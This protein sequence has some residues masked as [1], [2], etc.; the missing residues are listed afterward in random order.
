M[1]VLLALVAGLAGGT[2]ISA[3]GTSSLEAVVA[4]AETVGALWVAALRM[5]VVPLVV[6]LLVAS[7]ASAADVGAL[8]RAGGRAM[9]VF[10]ALLAVSATV[11]ALVAPALLGFA[12]VAA[13]ATQSPGQADLAALELAR[14]GASQL[15]DLGD[16]LVSLVPANPV[17]AAADGALLPLVVFSVLFAAAVTRLRPEQ[18]DRVVGPVEAIRDAMLVLV[19]W[20]IALAPIGVFALMLALGA[21]MGTSGA[22]ALGYYVILVSVLLA[23]QALLL[24]PLARL[25]GGVSVTRFARA[26]L[27]AQAVA[28]STRSSLAALPALVDGA[29]QV[30]RLP[31]AVAGFVL[32]LAVSVFK[33]SAPLSSV[34]GTLFVARL[35]QVDLTSLQVAFV[36]LAAVAL[37][38]STPGIPAG[39]LVVLAPVFGSLGLPLEGLGILI[40]LDVIPDTIKTTGNVTANVAVATIVARSSTS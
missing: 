12:P 20:I 17:K 29:E 13:D 25:A 27:P 2:A 35:Y 9:L 6:S 31:P 5:T 16:W 14:G 37:S 8:R 39:N 24:Y 23:A 7:V 26:A 33:F 21:R 11:A 10:V 38:F 32:P 36:A 22:G 19:R 1:R 30:L 34:V 28:V 4:A 15:P 40:A 18:R 3:S